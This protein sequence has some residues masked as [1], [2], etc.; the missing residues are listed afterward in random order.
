MCV[1]ERSALRILTRIAR[2]SPAVASMRSTGC[3]RYPRGKPKCADDGRPGDRASFNVF[4][5]AVKPTVP[6]G[7]TTT[8][9]NRQKARPDAIGAIAP[10]ETFVPRAR[11]LAGVACLSEKGAPRCLDGDVDLHGSQPLAPRLVTCQ[12]KFRRKDP[13]ECRAFGGSV[14][15]TQYKVRSGVTIRCVSL[16]ARAPNRAGAFVPARR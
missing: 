4:R 15:A 11:G 12:A 6:L 13:R 16:R 9:V 10:P 3:R 7:G 1:D 8:D 14:R 5:N 2:H